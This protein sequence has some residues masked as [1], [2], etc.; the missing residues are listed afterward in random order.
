LGAGNTKEVGLIEISY[1]G[2]S[3]FGDALELQNESDDV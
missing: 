3:K 1:F 2:K